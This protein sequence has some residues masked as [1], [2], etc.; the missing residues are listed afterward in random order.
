MI[1]GRAMAELLAQVAEAHYQALGMQPP[2]LLI[3]VP[4]HHKSLMQRGFHHTAFIAKRVAATLG[5]RANLLLKKQQHTP[6]QHQLSLEA[7]RTNLRDAF[8]LY[9]DAEELIAGK[10][11]VLLDDVMTTGSTLREVASLVRQCAPSEIS[12]WVVA[13]TP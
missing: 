5:I 6:A 7:R 13:R 3:P 10:R 1:C 11:V 12:V 8:A 4:L 2:D 9:S